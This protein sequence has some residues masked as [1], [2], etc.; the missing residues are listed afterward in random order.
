MDVKIV[1]EDQR[2]LDLEIINVDQSVLQIV[3]EELL[4]DNNVEFAAYSKPHPLLKSQT[5]SLIVKTGD[6]KKVFKDA[7][8]RAIK[9]AKR[10]E[11]DIAGALLTNGDF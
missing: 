7:C 6:P 10:L 3:Q 11:E 9:K 1:K 2:S 4:M 5:L 8:T